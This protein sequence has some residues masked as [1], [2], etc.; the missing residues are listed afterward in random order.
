MEKAIHLNGRGGDMQTR[1]SHPPLVILLHAKFYV[2]HRFRSP[3]T[4]SCLALL[5]PHKPEIYF[6]TVSSTYYL[7]HT[8]PVIFMISHQSH[9][10]A[11]TCAPHTHHCTAYM[12]S[13]LTVLKC[14]SYLR[15]HLKKISRNKSAVGV[16]Q[17]LLLSNPKM[18][19]S[20]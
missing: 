17:Q 10:V 7:L 19:R 9:S 5:G 2:D 12:A 1:D 15:V 8:R 3:N 18:C 4:A 6:E 14:F 16:I 11:T 13:Y 20:L